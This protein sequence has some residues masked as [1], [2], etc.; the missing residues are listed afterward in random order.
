MWLSGPVERTIIIVL[1]WFLKKIISSW[2]IMWE[3]V[4]IWHS[5]T[6]SLLECCSL[7]LSISRDKIKMVLVSYVLKVEFLLFPEKNISSRNSE[8]W[9]CIFSKSKRRPID[10]KRGHFFLNRYFFI[11][12]CFS[13][14]LLN[15]LFEF[16]TEFPSKLQVIYLRI[17]KHFM[18][19]FY[20]KYFIG[21]NWENYN[22]QRTFFF[23]MAVFLTG[24]HL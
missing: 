14:E 20:P 12:N 9:S 8:F 10:I 13:A 24:F 16:L 23:S 15:L 21:T 2:T 3:L 17:F 6:I 22:V 4:T 19:T 7:S 11:K 5:L 18:Y 1:S